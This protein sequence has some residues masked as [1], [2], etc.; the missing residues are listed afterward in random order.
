MVAVAAAGFGLTLLNRHQADRSASG[1][2]GRPAVV[3]TV[4]GTFRLVGGAAPG[5][6]RAVTGTVEARTYTSGG[7]PPDISTV[8]GR[9]VATGTTSSTGTFALSLP[10][11]R[12]VVRGRSS[13]VSAN[14]SPY[15]CFSDPVTVKAQ[16]TAAA[17][18]LCSVP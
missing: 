5:V 10:P 12:Y 9:L 7:T 8:T 16:Q 18:I 14:G 4:S 17:D 3:G 13:Q 11:G 2:V 6:N 1:Q 15:P